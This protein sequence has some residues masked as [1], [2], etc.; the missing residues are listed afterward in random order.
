MP[1][2]A[3]MVAASLGNVV[4]DPA[5]LPALLAYS[6]SLNPSAP[7]ITG[8]TINPQY[9]DSS[10]V[11]ANQIVGGSRPDV[12][13]PVSDT[14]QYPLTIVSNAG[15]VASSTPVFRNNLVLIK[16]RAAGLPTP[17]ISFQQVDLAHTVTPG[18]V[19]IYIANP[20]SPYNVPA[21][22]YARLAFQY[23]G[24]AVW[25]WIANNTGNNVT[26]STMATVTAVLTAVTN[27]NV[28]AIGA[29]YAT[30]AVSSLVTSPSVQNPVEIIAIAPAPVNIKVIYPAVKI[31]NSANPNG[32]T[33]FVNFMQT[34]VAMTT[35]LKWGFIPYSPIP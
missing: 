27:S 22:V 10:G 33:A 9:G 17:I 8:L 32:A 5:F 34:S 15:L 18:L 20:D 12:F 25:N 16:N 11:L 6:A 21:G 30:D 28:P 4:N 24:S 29:V 31:A 26:L 13:M 2:L 35:F 19:R 14:D 7:N 1:N 3:L 23:F